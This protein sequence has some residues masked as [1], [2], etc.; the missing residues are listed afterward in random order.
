MPQGTVKYFWPDKGYGFI[1]PDTGR[2]DVFIHV[3]EL[4]K[5]GLSSLVPGQIVTFDVQEDTRTGRPRAVNV[6]LEQ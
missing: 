3:S 5:A 6:R 2:I 1:A 4:G